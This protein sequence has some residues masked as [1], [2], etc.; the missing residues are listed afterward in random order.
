MTVPA[1]F[2]LFFY[3]WVVNIYRIVEKFVSFFFLKKK[4]PENI[5][6]LTI[7]KY[8]ICVTCKNGISLVSKVWKF[9]YKFWDQIFKISIYFAQKV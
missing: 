9:C 2:N 4:E 6:T 1:Y 7:Q 8:I 5:L 3:N